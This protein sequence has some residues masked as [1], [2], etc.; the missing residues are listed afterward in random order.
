MPSK[1]IPPTRDRLQSRALVWISVPLLAAALCAAAARSLSLGRAASVQLATSLALACIFGWLAWRLRAATPPAAFFGSAICLLLLLNARVPQT[2]SP[3]HTGLVPLILLF[4]LTFA[5][6]RGGRT[7]K[8]AAGLAEHRRGRNEAQVLANL[9]VAALA[10]CLAQTNRG[11]HPALIAM[12]AALAEAT[13]DTVSSEIGQAFGG[14]PRHLFTLRPLPPGTDGAVTLTGTSAGAAAA[15]LVAASAIPSLDLSIH[16]AAIAFAAGIAGLFLDSLLGATLET[17][18]W[19][20][21]DLVNLTS[22]AAAATLA[23]WLA[24]AP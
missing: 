6:T 4:L 1:T 15:A 21:N 11:S 7:R 14:V 13:A 8:R 19:I 3:L 22:T 5:A 2:A 9:G 10:T 16:A 20:G 24:P 18:G 17:C 12:L 23:W